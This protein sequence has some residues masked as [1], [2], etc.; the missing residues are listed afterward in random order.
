M[1]GQPRMDIWSRIQNLLSPPHDLW[2]GV[3]RRDHAR[4]L[5][6]RVGQHHR[7]LPGAEILLPA[8]RVETW[9]S[10]CCSAGC[11]GEKKQPTATNLPINADKWWEK[12]KGLDHCGSRE[13]CG[14]VSPVHPNAAHPFLP[15]MISTRNRALQWPR[16][17]HK[18]ARSTPHQT[19]H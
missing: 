16:R 15:H 19:R 4:W 13:S 6:T 17:G 9:T 12:T 7:P 18:P 10:F 11:G 3:V 5:P 1:D 14:S 2:C 8:I